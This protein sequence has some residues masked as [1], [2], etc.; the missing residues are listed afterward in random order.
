MSRN[1]QLFVV[2]YDSGHRDVR[3]GSGPL[4][5]QSELAMDGER[6]EAA[7][8]WRA[9]IS[10]AFQLYAQLAT[11]IAARHDSFPIVLGGNCGVCIGTASGTGTSDLGVIW[12]DA[13]GDFNTP[14]TTNTGFLD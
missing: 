11:R 12:F 13:H 9:E 8:D 10:T 14:E 5:L 6:I 2:P 4:R 7:A 1:R 3:M